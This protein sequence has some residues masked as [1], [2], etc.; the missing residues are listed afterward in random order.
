MR[1]LGDVV[2]REVRG[3]IAVH[4]GGE[5]HG[6]EQELRAGGRLG[7][8]G[9]HGVAAGGADEGQGALDQGHPEREHQR[10]VTQFRDHGVV[11]CW[12]CCSFQ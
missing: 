11:S 4:Q 9:E 2:D 5:G 6:H 7:D 3:D 1:V 10:V 8:T 12:P